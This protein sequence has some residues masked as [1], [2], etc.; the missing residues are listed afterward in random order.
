M[1]ADALSRTDW[2]K[3]V[4][5][6]QANSIQA[7]VTAAITGQ[8]NDHIEATP[9]SPQTIESLLSVP[10]N[11]QIVCKAITWSLEQSCLRHTEADSFA[12]KIASETGNFS[13]PDL[14]LNLQCMTMMDWMRAQAMDKTI[15]E[16]IER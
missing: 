2:E 1:E 10:D 4:E 14:S 15:V 9:C 3:G 11:A 5:T 12:S 16:I 13:H 8:G 6:I 7:I